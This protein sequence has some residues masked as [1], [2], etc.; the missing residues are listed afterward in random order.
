MKI[1]SDTI[2]AIRTGGLGNLI[3]AADG[4]AFALSDQVKGLCDALFASKARGVVPLAV[5]PGDRSI[6]LSDPMKAVYD[7]LFGLKSRGLGHL[8]AEDTEMDGRH[9]TLAG[10]RHVNFGSCSYEGLETDD[11]L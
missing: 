5:T 6:V 1:I 7:G 8:V 3:R 11:R 4:Q 10:R 9:V 2:D